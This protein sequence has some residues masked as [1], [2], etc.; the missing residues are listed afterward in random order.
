LYEEQ[1]RHLDYSQ[2]DKLQLN[3][4]SAV[5]KLTIYGMHCNRLQL[6]IA[7]IKTITSDAVLE[8]I[9]RYL[10]A[11]ASDVTYSKRKLTFKLSIR[12]ISLLKDNNVANCNSTRLLLDQF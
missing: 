10:D 4:M 5:L 9:S 12:L 11:V 8:S 6:R 2:Y 3:S 7:F 1:T